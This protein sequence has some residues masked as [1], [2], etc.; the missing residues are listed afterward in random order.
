MKNNKVL[1][2]VDETNFS[3]CVLPYL[4]YLL[5]PAKTE[6]YLLHVAPVPHAVTVGEQVLVYA[7]QETASV[8]AES[9]TALQPY[10]RS[11][12]EIGYHVAPFVS[13]GDPAKEI[14]RFVTEKE[15]DLVA[16]TTHGRTGLARAM[17]GSVAQHVLN[18]VDIPVLLYKANARDADESTLA[19]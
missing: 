12:E 9:R 10:V 1:V 2:P 11:L 7:D 17:L 16:M 18:H 6:L 14:E 15:I 3:L 4:T 19:W 13:F 8:E 5:E